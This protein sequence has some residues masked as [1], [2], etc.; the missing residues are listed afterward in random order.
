M[1]KALKKITMKTSRILKLM[2]VVLISLVLTTQAKAID[3][4]HR[5]ADKK[6]IT[7]TVD[8]PIIE[9][10]AKAYADQLDAKD[11]VRMQKML[12]QIDHIT[13]SFRD[14]DASDYV[15]KFKS[16][17]EQGLENWMFNAG[18]LISS[19]EPEAAPLEAWMLDVNYLE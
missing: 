5:N 3:R 6:A 13:V 2:G 19:P 8:K 9:F 17:D 15:L 4:T 18:Y 16:L 1:I 12:G 14:E 7:L 11:I 10:M